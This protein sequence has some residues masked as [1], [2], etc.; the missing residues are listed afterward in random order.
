[1]EIQTNSRSFSY[2]IFSKKFSKLK[3]DK[4]LVSL[5]AHNNQLNKLITQSNDGFEQTIEG[6]RNLVKFNNYVI[7]NIVVI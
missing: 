3:A 2:D 1:M 6:I 4:F 7:I 5:H